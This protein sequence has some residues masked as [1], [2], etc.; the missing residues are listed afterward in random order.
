MESKV[1]QT[2]GQLTLC[3]RLESNGG[4]G[5]VFES[6]VGFDDIDSRAWL[7][8]MSKSPWGYDAS[9]VIFNLSGL[10]RSSSLPYD[11]SQR[12]DFAVSTTLSWDLR[13]LPHHCYMFSS[14]CL[15][16]VQFSPTALSFLPR[17]VWSLDHMD[18]VLSSPRLSICEPDISNYVLYEVN[19]SD[20]ALAVWE[21]VLA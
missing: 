12:H 11:T 14:P 2:Q 21:Y 6:V 19:N 1:W 4:L 20:T 5:S 8:R 17:L 3:L 9:F 18:E 16:P 7:H 13:L 10:V 15:F